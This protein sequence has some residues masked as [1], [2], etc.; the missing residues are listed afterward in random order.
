[1]RHMNY[2][3]DRDPKKGILSLESTDFS[4]GVREF[5]SWRLRTTAP[6]AANLFRVASITPVRVCI[7][8]R[9]YLHM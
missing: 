1:M 2:N 5:C 3:L 6:K 9:V 4:T 7:C 8:E